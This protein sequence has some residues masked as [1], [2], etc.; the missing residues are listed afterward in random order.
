MTTEDK[1]KSI[2]KALDSKK[3]EDI[4]VIKITDLTIIADYFVIAGGTSSTHTKSLSQEVD[5][6]LGLEGVN[7]TRTEGSGA[8]GWVVLDYSDVVVH[9]FYKEERDFYQ[10]ERL[11]ADGEIIDISQFLDEE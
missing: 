8:D 5:Y 3:A 1:V 2:V 6:K 7:P 11:W 9:V 10:L 4:K